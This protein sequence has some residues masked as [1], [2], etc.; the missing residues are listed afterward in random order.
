MFTKIK[1][2]NLIILIFVRNIFLL[3]FF[4]YFCVIIITIINFGE[5]KR[6]VGLYVVFKNKNF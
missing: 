4:W 2:L 5:T 1:L 6:K 3:F